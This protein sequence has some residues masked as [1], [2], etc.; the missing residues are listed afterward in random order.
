MNAQ[1]ADFT[2]DGAPE[3]QALAVMANIEDLT[4]GRDRAIALWLESYDTLHA[5][6]DAAAA[7]SIGGRIGLQTPDDRYSDSRVTRAFLVSVRRAAMIASFAGTWL[8]RPVMISRAS[9]LKRSIAAAGL[10][11]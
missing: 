4:A 1:T 3:G 2:V 11:S 7:A 6:M 8:P 10:I 9:S 5:N